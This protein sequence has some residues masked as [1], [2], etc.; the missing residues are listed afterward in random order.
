[1]KNGL[2][3]I[4]SMWLSGALYADDQT[5]EKSVKAQFIYNFIN[6]VVWPGEAFADKQST[7]RLCT[8]G[9]V[10]FAEQIKIYQGAKV[11]GRQL[12]VQIAQHIQQIKQGC[13]ALFVGDDERVHLPELWQQIDYMYVLSLGDRE[14]FSERGGIITIFRTADRV[15]FDV[16]IQTAIENGLFVDS[17]L[18]ALARTIKRYTKPTQNTPSH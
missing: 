10:D 16:N 18:L 9:S 8:L 12:E 3:F 2:I 7:L 13:H 6:F 4:I 1:M 17:D 5:L 11:L 14:H 15:Q